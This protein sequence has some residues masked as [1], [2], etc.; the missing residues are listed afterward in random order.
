MPGAVFK[1]GWEAKEA[2]KGR[3]GDGKEIHRS[4]VARINFDGRNKTEA[5]M[6]IAKAWRRQGDG[7]K[8]NGQACH[9]ARMSIR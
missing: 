9:G 6:C 1:L 4:Q 7:G 2:Q 3:W 8:P 5:D